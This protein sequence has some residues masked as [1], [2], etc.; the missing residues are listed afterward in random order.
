MGLA[1]DRDRTDVVCARRRIPRIRT[2]EQRHSVETN[3]MNQRP[4]TTGPLFR[5]ARLVMPEHVLL[6]LFGRRVSVAAA[7]RRV[8]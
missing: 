4:I 7:S 2:R 6:L 5:L 1:N 3:P 8:G